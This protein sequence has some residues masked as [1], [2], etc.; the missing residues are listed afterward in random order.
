MTSTVPG[1]HVHAPTRPTRS[2]ARRLLLGAG[3][4]RAAWMS[5]LLDGRKIGSMQ[6]SRVVSGD[7]VVTTERMRIELDRS[8]TR[9][10]LTQTETD[11]ETIDGKIFPDGWRPQ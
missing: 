6:N 7:R 1:H 4:I 9:L 2:T 5:V 10:A 8:G 11:E 3:W